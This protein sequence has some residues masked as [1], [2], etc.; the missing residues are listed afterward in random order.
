MTEPDIEFVPCRTFG[1]GWAVPRTMA[2]SLAA[3]ETF[4]EG[5]YW[6]EPISERGYVV[7]PQDAADTVLALRAEGVTVNIA[8]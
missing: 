5:D 1:G 3:F 2:G 7:E 6:L 4:G 8:A